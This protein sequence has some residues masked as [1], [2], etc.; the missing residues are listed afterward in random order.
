MEEIFNLPP[1]ENPTTEEE[2]A[3]LTKEQQELIIA[4]DAAID[5]IDA[6]LPAVQQLDAESDVELDDIGKLARDKFNDMIDLG[7]NVDPRFAGPIL[8]TASTLLGHALAA[9]TAK[10][11][12]KLKMVELQ[13]RKAR[14]DMQERQEKSKNRNPH[15]PVGSVDEDDI[16]EAQVVDRNTLLNQVLEQVRKQQKTP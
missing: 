15:S 5:K 16:G 1:I 11:D 13:L 9:K 14:L 2:V 10:I 12:K 7:M 8:Q 4:A 3:A 6:A